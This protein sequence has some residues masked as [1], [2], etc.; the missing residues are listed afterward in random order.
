MIKSSWE[1]PRPVSY[2]YIENDE[3]REKVAVKLWRNLLR[4]QE[5]LYLRCGTA[6]AG[7]AIHTYNN[8]DVTVFGGN[9]LT[10]ILPP[11]SNEVAKNAV[12]KD[13]GTLN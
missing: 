3:E 1:N 11:I 5:E 10:K 2:N 4:I 6:V 7:Y 9:S 13:K 8:F 12:L